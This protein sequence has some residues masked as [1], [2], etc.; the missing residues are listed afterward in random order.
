MWPALSATLLACFALGGLL[1]VRAQAKRSAFDVL[2]DLRDHDELIRDAAIERVDSA[3]E[4][5]PDDGAAVVDVHGFY[6]KAQLRAFKF[7][8]RVAQVCSFIFVVCIQL[9]IGMRP[10]PAMIPGLVAAI[11]FCTILSTRLTQSRK[12]NYRRRIEYYL[13]LVMERL[14]MAVQA[15]HD[16]ISGVR[17]LIEVEVPVGS[18]K[19]GEE[20]L[21]LDPVTR[22]FS[23]AYRITVAGM[24]FDRA[25]NLVTK[26]IDCPAL[27]HAFI[28][29][30][31]AHKEGGELITPLKELSDATQ[32]YYQ[33]TVEEEI[34]KLPVKATAPLVCAFFGVLLVI[35][36]IPLAQISSLAGKVTNSMST[37]DGA[38]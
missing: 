16:I 17:T 38:K 31:L 22:L 10:G 4:E 19:R 21:S 24:P 28:H 20:E 8:I 36:C 25:L 1:F 3:Q 6:S 9:S 13:P 5:N 33:E 32:S 35:I 26:S 37:T 23:I 34:A 15:G 12:D 30:A 2:D 11:G 7:R 29:L 14:T 18:V 27:K